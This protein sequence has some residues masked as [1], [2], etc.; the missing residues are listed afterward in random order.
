M[1]RNQ[2]EHL[3]NQLRDL[4]HR[5]RELAEEIFNEVREGDAISSRS[6]YQKLSSVS[7]QAI[8]LMNKQKEMLD[9]ELNQLT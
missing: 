2:F 6:L 1:D 9:Q 4:G 8:T 5:R 7:E 3:G